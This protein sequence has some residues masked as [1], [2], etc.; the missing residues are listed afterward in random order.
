MK[1][2]GDNNLPMENSLFN[3]FYKCFKAIRV[4]SFNVNLLTVYNPIIKNLKTVIRNNLPILYSD[5]R[6]KNIFP[7][8]GINITY[9]RGKSLR[10]FISPSMF[11]QTQV[12]PHSVVS[13]CKSKRCDICQNYL[14]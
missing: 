7:E 8:G 4:S 13:K 6:M 14:E 11:P 9:K 1:H 5:P 3:F 12:E 2:F 10:E